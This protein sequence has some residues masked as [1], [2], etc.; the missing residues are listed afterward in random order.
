MKLSELVLSEPSEYKNI[1]G[2]CV[3][4]PDGKK[5]GVVEQV[6]LHNSGTIRYVI[7]RQDNG[8][9]RK[10]RASELSLNED[11]LM[12]KEP[13]AEKVL[14]ALVEVNKALTELTELYIKLMKNSRVNVDMYV[15]VVSLR[16]NNA[17][18]IVEKVNEYK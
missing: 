13:L 15:N 17:L 14:N 4:L 9:L 6:V 11:S 3:T 7:V 10:L 2:K 16:L 12:L 5:I 1:L 18:K 8:I